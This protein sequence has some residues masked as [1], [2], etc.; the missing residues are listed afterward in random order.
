MASDR[1]KL[2]QWFG[3]VSPINIT[4]TADVSKRR[5]S[6]R[7]DTT[8]KAYNPFDVTKAKATLYHTVGKSDDEITEELT[9][10]ETNSLLLKL[11]KKLAK[12][13]E[14]GEVAANDVDKVTAKIAGLR[15]LAAI[16]A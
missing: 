8:S 12:R 11:A 4:Y 1:V 9:S 14:A 15:Q 7:K 6:L 13:L 10:A 5:V 16:A 2:I 3:L